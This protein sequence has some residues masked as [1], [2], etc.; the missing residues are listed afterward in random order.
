MS[1]NQ[2]CY[3][4]T[5]DACVGSAGSASGPC[6]SSVTLHHAERVAPHRIAGDENVGVGSCG[7]MM[8]VS[9]GSMKTNEKYSLVVVKIV[10]G[11]YWEA[12]H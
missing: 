2:S 5:S 3:V 7:C 8:S 9:G 12:R 11:L 10:R 4:Y 6:K 1:N